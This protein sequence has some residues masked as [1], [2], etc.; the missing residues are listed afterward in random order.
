MFMT[1]YPQFG[2]NEHLMP[3]APGPCPVIDSNFFFQVLPD[4]AQ[5]VVSLFIPVQKMLRYEDG[6]CTMLLRP[7]IDATFRLSVVFFQ[8]YIIS[9]DKDEH[10]ISFM[11]REDQKLSVQDQVLGNMEE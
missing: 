2:R 6:R 7:S 3:E 11:K 9:F 10:Q 5:D 4:S 1:N 8:E